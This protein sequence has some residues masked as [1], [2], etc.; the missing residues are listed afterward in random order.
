[1]SSFSWLIV[2]FGIG[3]AGSNERLCARFD[4]P[5]G[6]TVIMLHGQRPL[7]PEDELEWA[8]GS[9]SN[10]LRRMGLVWQYW[11]S[12]RTLYWVDRPSHLTPDR[13]YGGVDP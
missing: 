3:V 1:M 7:T 8:L 5:T 12:T 10:V 9:E 13:V 2:A 11:T 4:D 6:V